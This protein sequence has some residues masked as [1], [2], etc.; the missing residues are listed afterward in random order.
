MIADLPKY[1][2]HRYCSQIC[3][4]HS[5]GPRAPN[6]AA[7]RA[8]RPPYEELKAELAATNFCAVA[9]ACGVSDIAVRK[10]LRFHK[11]ERERERSR[12]GGAD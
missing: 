9:R 1:E 12:G 6:L 5:A 11:R 4:V 3:G 10:W 8:E 7:R 2:K